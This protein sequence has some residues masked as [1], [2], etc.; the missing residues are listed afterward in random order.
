MVS[1]F[2]SNLASPSMKSWIHI[3][4]LSCVKMNSFVNQHYTL[5]PLYTRILLVHWE[6]TEKNQFLKDTD[7]IVQLHLDENSTCIVVLYIIRIIDSNT[8]CGARC[9]LY[10]NRLSSNNHKHKRVW[11]YLSRFWNL[12]INQIYFLIRLIIHV[13]NP[14]DISKV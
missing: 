14:K 10:I 11:L 1:N 5:S 7:E 6:S 13:H 8:I 2:V 4:N 12:L 3:D 9:P